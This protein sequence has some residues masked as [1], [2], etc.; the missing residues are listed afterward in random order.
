M[1][2][3]AVKYIMKCGYVAGI[4]SRTLPWRSRGPYRRHKGLHRHTTGQR[5]PTRHRRAL[6]IWVGERGGGRIGDHDSCHSLTKKGRVPFACSAIKKKQDCGREHRCLLSQLV[7]NPSETPGLTCCP[8]TYCGTL[9]ARDDSRYLWCSSIQQQMPSERS[10]SLQSVSFY[11]ACYG[12]L[13]AVYG[14]S[15]I[16]GYVSTYILFKRLFLA[17]PSFRVIVDIT[18]TSATRMVAKF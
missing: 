4:H 10:N 5:V 2:S 14:H 9:P 11:L 18:V 12:H 6:A 7:L 17:L 3:V 15:C 16:L 13:V 1:Q 8:N